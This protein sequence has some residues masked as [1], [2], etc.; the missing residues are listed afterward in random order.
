[1]S[2]F[3]RH[4]GD[5]LDDLTNSLRDEAAWKV[6]ILKRLG[7]NGDVCCL[8]VEPLSGLL[9]V[10]T[11]RGAVHLFGSLAASV[12]LAIPGAP[13]R[14]PKFLNFAQALGKLVVVGKAW[15]GLW[16]LARTQPRSEQ[17]LE[18]N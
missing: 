4:A 10:G 7:L 6:G 14:V 15:L 3:G 2:F 18:A 11:S 8:A 13:Y 9:A 17:I 16:F 1:M 5:D 12:E